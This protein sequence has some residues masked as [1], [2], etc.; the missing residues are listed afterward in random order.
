ME[1]ETIKE[2]IKY[3][4]H[5]LNTCRDVFIDYPSNKLG[6]QI[7]FNYHHIRSSIRIYPTNQVNLFLYAFGSQQQ[8]LSKTSLLH[9]F[10]NDFIKATYNHKHNIFTAPIEE[11]IKWQ[12]TYRVQT[13]SNFTSKH[14]KTE[15][16]D[17]TKLFNIPTKILA[18]QL[19]KITAAKIQEK[20]D[21]KDNRARLKRMKLRKLIN[22][23]VEHVVSN[24]K[25]DALVKSQQGEFHLNYSLK[26]LDLEHTFLKDY[27]FDEVDQ[28]INFFKVKMY[29][30]KM[31]EGFHYK[32]KVCTTGVVPNDITL[33]ISWENTQ[34]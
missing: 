8:Y 7:I 26:N 34:N 28:K 17:T 5:K 23:F 16:F 11:L 31:L 18:K 25:Q 13:N 27:E 1:F 12:H 14:N 29:L 24:F 10:K 19:Q 6:I 22:D 2:E 15:K 3:L 9:N 30:N 21:I 32:I 20:E 4:F 33:N